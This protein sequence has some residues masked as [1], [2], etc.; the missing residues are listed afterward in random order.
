MQREFEFDGARFRTS[1]LCRLNYCKFAANLCAL[2]PSTPVSA[3]RKIHLK[4]SVA[5]LSI[6]VN[7]IACAKWE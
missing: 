6:A 4:M 3:Q 2:Q 7:L 5:R 1:A